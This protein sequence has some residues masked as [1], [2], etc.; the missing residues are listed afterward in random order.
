MKTAKGVIFDFNGTLFFDTKFHIKAFKEKLAEAGKPLPDDH[1]LIKNVFGKPNA[2]VYREF[3]ILSA[4]ALT[5]PPF[6][7]TQKLSH[8]YNKCKVNKRKKDKRIDRV[9]GVGTDKVCR[10][11]KVDDGD[12]AR[13]RG[14]L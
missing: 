9:V 13:N 7:D 8:Y 1:Y 2:T 12:V 3:F 4:I 5:Q 10:T 14:L 11:G 6:E